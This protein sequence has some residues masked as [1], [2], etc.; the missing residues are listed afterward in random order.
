LAVGA[1]QKPSLHTFEMAM[2]LSS[3]LYVGEI[4]AHTSLDHFRVG[5]L[6]GLLRGTERGGN[7]FSALIDTYAIL[8]KAAAACCCGPFL[9]VSSEM[10]KNACY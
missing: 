6:G 3:F 1:Y 9:L 5:L 7:L 2:Q 8:T 10:I 4:H